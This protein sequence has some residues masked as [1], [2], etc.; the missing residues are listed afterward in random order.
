MISSLTTDVVYDVM[1]N[2]PYPSEFST[3][4]QSSD[5][6]TNQTQIQQVTP[7]ASLTLFRKV[8]FFKNPAS[9]Q[10]VR[11]FGFLCFHKLWCPLKKFTSDEF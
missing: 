9:T 4:A 5:T 3:I 8:L 11:G 2:K 10:S 1:E 6:V 7:L